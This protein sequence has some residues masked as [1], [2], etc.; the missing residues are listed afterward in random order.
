MLVEPHRHQTLAMMICEGWSSE[1]IASAMC[2]SEETVKQY[3][4]AVAPESFKRVLK[5]YREK[6]ERQSIERRFRLAEH[7]EQAY[8]NIKDAL[9]SNDLKF[10][11][12]TAWRILDEVAPKPV[13]ETA[14][15]V[16]VNVNLTRNSQVNAQIVQLSQDLLG[17][18]QTLK[19]IPTDGYQRHLKTGGDALPSTYQ[20]V[21]DEE[22]AKKIPVYTKNSDEE[23]VDVIEGSPRPE[24]AQ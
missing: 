18:F 16:S 5:G 12:E 7:S 1:D 3:G 22:G 11:T 9:H 10:K 4:S 21:I 19:E 17:E 24:Q 8:S 20:D 14:P 13:E 6:F 2:I 15:G 23:K